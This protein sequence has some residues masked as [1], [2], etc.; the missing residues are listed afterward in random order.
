MKFMVFFLFQ[1]GFMV[2]VDELIK[3]IPDFK[4]LK[5]ANK[6]LSKAILQISFFILMFCFR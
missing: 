3:P 6:F 1:E 2:F 5:I 4:M